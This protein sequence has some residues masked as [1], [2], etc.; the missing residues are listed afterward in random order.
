MNLPWKS[1]RNFTRLCDRDY[2]HA[3]KVNEIKREIDN[4]NFIQELDKPRRK[5]NWEKNEK[6]RYLVEV[7]SIDAEYIP[8]RNNTVKR[9]NKWVQV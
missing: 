4:I 9:V 6:V 5:S 3:H 2:L 7:K 8:V 1:Q